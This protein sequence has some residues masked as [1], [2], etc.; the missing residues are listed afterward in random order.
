M[1]IDIRRLT[2]LTIGIN[3]ESGVEEYEFDL[4]PW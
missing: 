1:T 3:T 2:R 4:F